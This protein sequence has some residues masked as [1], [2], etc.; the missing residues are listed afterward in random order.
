[1]NEKRI[2]KSR[3]LKGMKTSFIL[4]GKKNE[5]MVSTLTNSITNNISGSTVYIILK[6]Y[7]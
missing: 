5:L 2:I 7:N 1:M 4:L 6:V 3:V